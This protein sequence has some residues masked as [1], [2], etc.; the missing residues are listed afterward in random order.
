MT[1]K[2]FFYGIYIIWHTIYCN[3]K[4][5]LFLPIVCTVICFQVFKTLIMHILFEIGLMIFNVFFIDVL[6]T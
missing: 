1:I 5:I 2:L 3:I 6:L 4:I